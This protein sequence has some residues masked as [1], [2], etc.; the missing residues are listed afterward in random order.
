LNKEC[1]ELQTILQG[2]G[3]LTTI[4]AAIAGIC[5]LAH[6]LVLQNIGIIGTA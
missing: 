2:N 4:S 3:S 5:T 6:A 1:C